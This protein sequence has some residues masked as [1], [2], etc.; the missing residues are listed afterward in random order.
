MSHFIDRR[1]NPKGKSL[2][3]RLRFLRRAR[4]QIREAVQKSLKDAAV[5]DIGNDRKVRISTKGTREPRF[6]LD[7]KAGGEHDFVLPGNK[8]FM[9]GDEIKKPHSGEGKSRGKE[10]ADFGEG[11]DDFEFTMTQDEI[12]D[13]FF[14]DL[15]LPNLVRTTLKD[16]PSRTWKR[17][18]ITT[19]GSPTRINLLRTMRNAYGRRLA[20]KRPRPAD[21][22]ALQAR[23]DMLEQG[24]TEAPQAREQIAALKEELARAL[25]RQKWIAFIDPVDVRFNAFT[26]QAVP[27]SQAV[28]FCLMDVSG[29]MGE[30]EKDL[31]KRFYMLLH[32]F[33]KRRYER[34][35]IVFIRHTHDA[36]EVDEQEFFYSRQSGGTIVSTALEKMLEIQRER[37]VTADWNI[38]AAQ[39][40]DGYTQSGD[41]R[42]CV[43][44]LNGQI[45]PLCQYY[46]YIEILDER[47]MEVFANEDSGAEL[48]RAYRTA[49]AFWPNF[50]TKRI[51]KPADIF[52]VFRELFK[53]TEAA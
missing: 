29:S 8:E 15:A 45:M 17:A 28:M 41:A 37:Y 33:L 20:L 23:L 36:Q 16:T 2:A 4:T 3:N 48:W 47:E 19:S 21:I 10:A 30:R 46:A 35:D 27:T 39:A 7:P 31:A 1:L 13:I 51:A 11:E 22:D 26:E 52:P 6:R 34:V 50:A 53:K 49:A 32:L 9:P 14:E 43:E 12:L 44:M 5:A 40:S 24:A 25:A 42:H 38:Y 18:G